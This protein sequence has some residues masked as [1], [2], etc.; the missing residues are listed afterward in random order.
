[1][2]LDPK[3]EHAEYLAAL[4]A[5]HQNSP[6]SRSAQQHPLPDPVFTLVPC[7][8]LIF[9]LF[10][11]VELPILSLICLAMV[12]K[13]CSTLE[14]FF[15]DVSRNGIPRLSANSYSILVIFHPH[16][17]P[18]YLTLAV[19]YSTTFLSVISDLLPTKSLLTPSVA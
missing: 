1:M 14:A 6:H 5:L 2:W 3:D 13:A 15:A 16:H 17:W 12:K 19:V 8:M 11:C 9:S 10:C 18:E 7:P 4:V